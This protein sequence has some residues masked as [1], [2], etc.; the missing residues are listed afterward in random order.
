[1]LGT[2]KRE[3]MINT[4]KYPFSATRHAHDIELRNNRVYIE[5]REMEDT[6]GSDY[7][8]MRKLQILKDKLEDLLGYCMMGGIVY[9][10]GEHIGLA[11]ETVAWA[12]CYR[13]TKNAMRKRE[14]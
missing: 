2:R 4:K 13:D 8:T 1:M 3:Q 10:D 12:T 5:L 7:E 9:L 14:Q 6:K 11:K